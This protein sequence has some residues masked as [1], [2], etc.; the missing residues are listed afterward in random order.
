MTT[1]TINTDCLSLLTDI[2][3]QRVAEAEARGDTSAY[4]AYTSAFS[5]LEYTIQNDYPS[6]SQFLH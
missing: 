6:L 2:L 5:M 4:I 1:T 3:N